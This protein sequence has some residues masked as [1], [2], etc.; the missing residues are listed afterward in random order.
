MSAYLF[1][2]Y[3]IVIQIKCCAW[4]LADTQLGLVSVVFPPLFMSRDPLK[5]GFYRH[6]PFFFQER[7]NF[8]F[9]SETKWIFC[10]FVKNIYIF[11]LRRKKS[12]VSNSFF[13]FRGKQ[14]QNKFSQACFHM[15]LRVFTD[16]K[17]NVFKKRLS[18]QSCLFSPVY[19]VINAGEKTI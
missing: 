16:E 8:F 19:R 13:F 15:F 6:K 5:K 7:N 4:S 14:L 12:F 2:L 10:I 3:W 1:H 18:L 9:V 17:K 11:F